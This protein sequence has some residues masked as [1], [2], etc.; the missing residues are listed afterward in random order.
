MAADK[1][2]VVITKPISGLLFSRIFAIVL[3]L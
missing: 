2:A 1:T 3:A